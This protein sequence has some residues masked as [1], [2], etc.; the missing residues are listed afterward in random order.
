MLFEGE[1]MHCGLSASASARS[2]PRREGEG[3]VSLRCRV[4]VSGWCLIEN[5]FT[6]IRDAA[7]FVRA[8][9]SLMPAYKE[10]QKQLLIKA[11]STSCN[12]GK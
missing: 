3:G 4:T 9:A 12:T 8:D 1:Q 2:Q 11:I 10:G 5:A 6:L 7:A